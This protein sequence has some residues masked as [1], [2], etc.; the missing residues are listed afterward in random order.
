MA[1]ASLGAM[2][3]TEF[4]EAAAVMIFYQTG[5]LFQ[6]VAVGK[7]RKSV[8]ALTEIRPDTANLVGNDGVTE[9]DPEDVS[10]GS[11]I[12]V[13]PGERIPLDGVIIEGRTTLDAAAL[14][15]EAGL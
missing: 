5:E 9:V 7:S 11:V 15:G 14:T 1:V 2:A 10:V 8:A 13:Y 3:L 6:S 4:S 12:A